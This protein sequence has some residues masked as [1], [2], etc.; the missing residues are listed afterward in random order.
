M[1]ITAKTLMVNFENVV[2][3]GNNDAIELKLIHQAFI[4]RDKLGGIDVDIELVDIVDVKFLGIAIETGY[5]AY[6]NFKKQMLEFGIDVNDLVDKKA[7]EFEGE[8]T[9][10]LFKIMF[11]DSI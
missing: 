11:G 6:T 1:K 4:S 8:S 9:Q 2:T 3:L 7:E 10:T 5:E